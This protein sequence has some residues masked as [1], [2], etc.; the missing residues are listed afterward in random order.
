MADKINLLRSAIERAAA[1][2]EKLVVRDADPERNGNAYEGGFTALLSG[3][4]A[5]AELHVGNFMA[6]VLFTEYGD[7]SSLHPIPEFK[8]NIE[9]EESA[10]A[11]VAA[12]LERLRGHVNRNS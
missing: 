1:N 5:R 4:R 6:E 10:D 7:G 9:D 3:S 8:Q 12:V 2:D 11:V